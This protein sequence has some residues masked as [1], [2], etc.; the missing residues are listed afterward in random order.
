MFNI[1]VEI[2]INI[3]IPLAPNMVARAINRTKWL[4]EPSS[5]STRNGRVN[6]YGR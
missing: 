5:P 2:E 1:A 4:R 3:F 6:T